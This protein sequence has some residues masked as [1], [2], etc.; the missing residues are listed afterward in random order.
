MKSY[1]GKSDMSAES[2]ISIRSWERKLANG[3]LPFIRVGRR[4]LVARNDFDAFMNSR[5]M[6]NTPAD[7]R[8][9][10]LKI[11]VDALAKRKATA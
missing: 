8:S 10:L 11:A 2:D 9:K 3:E 4:V 7:V 1:L 6:Q 5:R